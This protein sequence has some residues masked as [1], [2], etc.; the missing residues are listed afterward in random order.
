MADRDFIVKNGL[1]VNTNLIVATGG[2]VGI[3]NTA[4]DATLTVGGTANIAGNTVL[5][6]TLTIAGIINAISNATFSANTSISKLVVNTTT[7]DTNNALTIVGSAN[8]TGDIHLGGNLY[9][10]G[11]TI[12]TGNT[13]SNGS[14]IPVSNGYF[15]GNTTSIWTL[16]ANTIATTG[17]VSIGNTSAPVSLSV[18][19]TDAILV[20]VGNTGQRPAGSNGY[21]RYNSQLAQFEGYANGAWGAI[22]GSNNVFTSLITPNVTTSNSSI[23]LIVQNG[24]SAGPSVTFAAATPTLT[25]K[26][27]PSVSA[28]V[29]NTAG[30]F[31]SNSSSNST[32]FVAVIAANGNVG[33]NNAAPTDAFSVNGNIVSSNVVSSP[34]GLHATSLT[35]GNSTI[36][37]STNSTLLIIGS[38]QVNTTNYF[39]GNSTVNGYLNSTSLILNNGTSNLNITVPSANQVSNGNF[40]LNA[41][42]SFTYIPIFTAAVN[43]DIWT[44]TSTTA[45]V[46]PA[47]MMLAMGEVTLTDAANVAIDFT[48]GLNFK[49]T[50]AGN[51][52]FV[53]TAPTSAI[54]GRSGYIK[55][56]QDAT[57][58]RTMAFTDSKIFT[59]NGESPI[60][61]TGANATDFIAYTIANTSAVIFSL[62]RNLS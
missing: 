31:V 23:D 1:V 52:T 29:V 28:L 6:G 51:R 9:L 16:Y 60:L 44:G 43:T 36:N 25:F 41:N 32:S 33:I 11:T 13:I 61:S 30:I 58:S 54:V 21:F 12:S 19:S 49:V 57:G 5:S 2:K 55:V 56:V 53:L 26:P 42:S 15:L 48:T 7:F 59:I 34:I 27:I 50:L 20:P 22:N 18:Q 45:Y 24:N 37:V 14:I 38:L 62:M 8:V 4:P 3:A 46:T 17:N 40:F 35:V 39:A 47:S 10:T